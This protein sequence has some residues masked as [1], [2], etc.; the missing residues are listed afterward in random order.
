ME[1]TPC[2]TALQR[3]F[4]QIS[5]R[6]LYPSDFSYQPAKCSFIRSADLT[7][8]LGDR[9]R[10]LCSAF[11]NMLRSAHLLMQRQAKLLSYAKSVNPAN[12][13]L[14]QMLQVQRFGEVT[15]NFSRKGKKNT[16]KVSRQIHQRLSIA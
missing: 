8:I 9:L 3:I 7:D 13:K 6:N 12:N 2:P 14:L 15:E 10:R 5:Q 4:P 11:I 16:G 1:S